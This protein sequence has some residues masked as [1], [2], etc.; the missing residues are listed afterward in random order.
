[1]N[2]L[3][4]EWGFLTTCNCCNESTNEPTYIEK[5]E[6]VAGDIQITDLTFCDYCI[7][8]NTV[9]CSCCGEHIHEYDDLAKQNITDLDG[10]NYEFLCHTCH[11]ELEFETAPKGEPTKA[12]LTTID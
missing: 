7:E 5:Y 9:E 2:N 3:R 6:M 8:N 10:T 4:N 1:M 12:I 11:E